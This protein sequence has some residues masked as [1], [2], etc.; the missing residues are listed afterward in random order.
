[1]TNTNDFYFDLKFFKSLIHLSSHFYSTTNYYSIILT[2]LTLIISI[3]SE[4][5]GYYLGLVPGQCYRALMNKDSSSFF[6]IFWK[7]SLMYIGKCCLLGALTTSGWFLYIVYRSNITK[8]LHKE[9]FK[10][11]TS[12]KV[13]F[14]YENNI[15][16]P[17]Q[18]ITQDVD[19]MCNQLANSI[20]PAA[21]ICPFVIAYYTYKTYETTGIYGI[22]LIYLYFIF[23]TIVNRILISPL[24]KWTGRV[25]KYEGDLRYK[26]VTIK[27]NCEQINFYKAQKFENEASN[28]FLYKLLENHY[29]LSWWRFP[30]SFWQNL[31]NYY[32]GFLSYAIQ[33]IPIFIFNS[34][35]DLKPSEL[36]Q[37]I[38]NNAFIYIYLI[39]SFTRLTDTAYIAGQMAGVLQ[40]V[41]QLLKYM[42]EINKKKSISNTINEISKD[43]YVLII[44]DVIISKPN[45]GVLINK[46]SFN[47]KKND[48]LLIFGNSGVGKTSLLRVIANIWNHDSGKIF[49][50]YSTNELAIVPQKPYFPTGKLTLLQQLI[51]PKKLLDINVSITDFEN[52]IFDLISMLKLNDLVNRIGSLFT[53]PQFEYVDLTPGELQRLAIIR[54]LLTN[55][56]ILLLDESTS[57]ISEEMEEIFYEYLLENSITFISIGHRKT[58]SKWHNHILTLC[59]DGTYIYT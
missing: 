4:V 34:F 28:D 27:N 41:S 59:C 15:D 19:K 42:E 17:D 5:L 38:S 11:N 56:K 50:K 45:E 7:G 25:E 32:G 49:C 58:L 37:V 29:Y 10:N 22:G 30:N 53:Q 36:A 35:D 47:L 26:H 52:R 13:N 2:L 20:M 31:F 39:N 14:N 3:S 57:S 16:N 6:N 23:G 48:S 33:Y 1:M 55:P 44:E 24:A 21:L 54:G 8:S 9:Y 12:L 51:F 43:N 18:R 40:R 46:L